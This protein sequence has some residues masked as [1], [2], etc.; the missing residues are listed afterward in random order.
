MAHLQSYAAHLREQELILVEF[1][2]NL[3]QLHL[4]K[5][6]PDFKRMHARNL[7]DRAGSQAQLSFVL[8]SLFSDN[9][10]IMR[11]M[12]PASSP[13]EEQ[14]PEHVARFQRMMEACR[15]A[16]EAVDGLI[17]C[18][19]VIA[20]VSRLLRDIRPGGAELA[21]KAEQLLLSLIHI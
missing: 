7:Y 9:Q 6:L 15:Q 19:L 3:S 21:D 18:R 4:L 12:R 17:A 10:V 11:D 8:H 5:P 13:E 14:A 1:D 16:K 20:E 2:D